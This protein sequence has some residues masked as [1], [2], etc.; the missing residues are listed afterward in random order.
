M[1]LA[2]TGDKLHAK[3]VESSIDRTP[4]ENLTC[5]DIFGNR[6]RTDPAFLSFVTELEQE[7]KKTD[8]LCIDATEGGA[9]EKR[10]SNHEA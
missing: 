1:D 9:T 7:I 8:A 10:N 6:I 3:D 2:F 4:V 5:E